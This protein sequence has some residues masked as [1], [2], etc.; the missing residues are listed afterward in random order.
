[1]ANQEDRVQLKKFEDEAILLIQKGNIL[2][3]IEELEK[4]MV[5]EKRWYHL[6]AKASWLYNSPEKNIDEISSLIQEGFLRF[7]DQRF[8]F[9]YIRVDV[10]RFEV[11]RLAAANQPNLEVSLTQ[12]LEAQKD[13]DL[14]ISELRERPQ[15]IKATL[16]NPPDLFSLIFPA[17][18]MIEVYKRVNDTRLEIISVHQTFLMMKYVF[19]AENRTKSR[20][21]K[22][23]MNMQ[24]E[25]MR[26]I[27]LLG[28]FTAIIAF[29]IL[30]GNAAFKTTY[31]EAMPILGGLSL[32]LILF[33][34]VASLVTSKFN[35]CLDILKD[36]RFLLAVVL[37]I[38]LGFLLWKS[39]REQQN[40]D[41]P[42]TNGIQ[43]QAVEVLDKEEM[44]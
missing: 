7:P 41:A 40:P 17:K 23:E 33:I 44:N 38:I 29:I 39:Q 2:G 35:R 43:S 18:E 19:D 32:V 5:I 16:D 34:T 1:M 12:L 13:I 20:I 42:S 28:F 8:W 36:A 30:L 24:S 21:Y 4:A 3:A 15:I 37:I 27:E 9:L 6:Y 26:T 11:V 22:Q 25:K 31:N 14:A 10:R